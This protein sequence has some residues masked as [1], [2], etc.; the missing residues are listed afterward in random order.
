MIL[1]GIGA[2]AADAK[3]FPALR[4]SVG[5]DTSGSGTS[6]SPTVPTHATN[7][8]LIAFVTADNDTG[9]AFSASAGW[10][11]I[12]QS[13]RLA[14]YWRVASGAAHTLTVTTGAS[15]ANWKASI[16]VIIGSDGSVEAT[17]I[18]AGT[19]DPASLAATWLS[20]STLWLVALSGGALHMTAPSGFENKI[21][22]GGGSPPF[23]TT[24]QKS[25]T[26]TTLDP[27]VFSGAV[28]IANWRTITVAIKPR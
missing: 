22:G 23:L 12:G 21:E 14:V 24:A 28:V 8:V 6:F 25:D 5:T 26:A 2:I 13:G 27:G 15:S 4:G 7:D 19:D 3:S 9:G 20:T 17:S 11:Q 16:Y 10:T 18:T 1:P